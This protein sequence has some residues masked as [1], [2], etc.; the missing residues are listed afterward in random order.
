MEISPLWDKFLSYRIMFLLWG[1][2]LYHPW[3]YLSFLSW[4]WQVLLQRCQPG[5]AWLTLWPFCAEKSV[6][7]KFQET[8]AKYILF[9]WLPLKK[10]L[11]LVTKVQSKSSRRALIALNLTGKLE[12]RPHKTEPRTVSGGAGSFGAR[13]ILITSYN[14]VWGDIHWWCDPCSSGLSYYH[15]LCDCFTWWKTNKEPREEKVDKS[16]LLFANLLKC[17]SKKISF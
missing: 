4:Y 16:G 11:S 8:C 3:F 1:G 2:P 13:H 15:L 12:V 7:I 5:Y 10:T 6:K 9:A 14:L 17:P